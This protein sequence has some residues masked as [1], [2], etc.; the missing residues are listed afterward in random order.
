MIRFTSVSG[1][2]MV[3]SAYRLFELKSAE[4]GLDNSY[5]LFFAQ[6]CGKQDSVVCLYSRTD[7]KMK[8]NFGGNVSFQLFT[9]NL[10]KISEKFW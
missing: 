9:E 10:Q 6:N 3:G 2:G 8:G 7:A 4:V 1:V 5:V